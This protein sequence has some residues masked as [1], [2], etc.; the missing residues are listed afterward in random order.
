VLPPAASA[1]QMKP[2]GQRFRLWC[3]I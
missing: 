3:L 1:R 2:Q